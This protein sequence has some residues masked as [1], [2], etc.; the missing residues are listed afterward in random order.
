MT[1][2][3]K[4]TMFLDEIGELPLEV[5]ASLLRTLENKTYRRVGDKDERTTDIR[6]IFATNRNLAKE[7]EAG[8]FHEALYHRI[9]VFNIELPPLR[10][11]KE[12]IPLLVDY[13]LGRLQ[14][15]GSYR[16]SDRA[17]GCLINYHWPGNIRELRNVIERGVILSEAGVITENALPRELSVKA[18][19]EN[20]FLSLEAV[21]REHIAKVLTCFGNNRTLA[22][23]ALGISRKTLYRKIR[24]Y[25]IM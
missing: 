23:S 5:Q 8:R 18:E 16:V 24:E 1:F 3:N 12:D 7:V 10:E 4:G 9:N 11:R 2:A 20:D 19:G 17:M 15:G 22:A 21:E 14:G 13:F 25:D 6:L